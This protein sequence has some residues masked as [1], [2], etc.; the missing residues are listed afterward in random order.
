MEEYSAEV[1]EL[2]RYFLNFVLQWKLV[3]TTPYDYIEAF[4]LIIRKENAVVDK[5]IEGVKDKAVQIADL[6]LMCTLI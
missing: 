4:A 2:E 6:L 3:Y 1:V 5:W